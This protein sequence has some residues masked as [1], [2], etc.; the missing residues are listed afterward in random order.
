[1]CFI[2]FVAYPC[3]A[4]CSDLEVRVR[5]QGRP[6]GLLLRWLVGVLALAITCAVSCPNSETLVLYCIISGGVESY[7]L[8]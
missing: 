8:G 1:M 7:I 2:D 4:A 6:G 5:G 3:L